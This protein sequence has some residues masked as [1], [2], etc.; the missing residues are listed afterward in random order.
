MNESGLVVTNEHVVDEDVSV[1]VRLAAGG[2]YSG[3]VIDKHSTLDLAYVQID[4]DRSFTPIAIGDS[5]NA[6]VGDE[7]VAI[8]FPYFQDADAEPTVSTGIISARRDDRLQTDAA[9]NPGNSGGPLLNMFG[10]VVGIVVSRVEYDR[11]GRAIA[12]IG[13]AIPVNNVGTD[14]KEGSNKPARIP[15]TNELLGTPTPP[16]TRTPRP[17]ATPEPTSIPFDIYC[18]E[19]REDVMEW[20][21]QGHIYRIEVTGEINSK[22]PIHPELEKIKK[23]LNYIVP[24]YGWCEKELF[25][26]PV[27]IL[28]TGKEKIVGYD[29]KYLLPGTYEY[30]IPIWGGYDENGKLEFLGYDKLADY[31]CPIGKN[32]RTQPSSYIFGWASSD[33]VGEVV[34]LVPGEPFTIHF[35]EENRRVYFSRSGYDGLCKGSL[36]R[37]GD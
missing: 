5:S 16:P 11:E 26:F 15:D 1:T 22:A 13:F 7:V 28:W 27:G 6:R 18:A 12:G 23:E 25:T 19:W 30:K 32:L 37:I 36:Y 10:Q 21:G 4:S 17:S 3:R 8:G 35:T 31:N 14:I 33:E 34:R 20:L 9:L 29:A 2:R 24:G